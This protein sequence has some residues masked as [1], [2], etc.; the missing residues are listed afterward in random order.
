MP[1]DAVQPWRAGVVIPIR[2]FTDA[3]A[4]LAGLLDQ[5]ARIDA[6]RQMAARVVDAAHSLPVVVV[7]RAPEVL[8][9]ASE[10]GIEVVADPGGLDAAAAAGRAFLAERGVTRVVIAHADLPL[11]RDLRP[12]AR[13]GER[14]VVALVP[15]HRDDGTNVLSVPADAPFEFAYGPGSFRRH[16]REARRLGLG[17]RVVRS[18][19]LAVD[20]DEADDLPYLDALR[21]AT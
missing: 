9:W 8:T 6:A 13:D 5:D 12:L 20:V 1:R 11:A 4:R 21:V 17:V 3:K 2:S 14:A 10:R 16:A 7:S 19:E 15:C 18:P